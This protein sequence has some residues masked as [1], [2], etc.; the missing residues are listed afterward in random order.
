MKITEILTESLSRVAFHYASLPTALRIMQSGE[1]RLSA[2]TGSIEQQYAPKG[3]P[4]FLSATRTMTGGYHA[5]VHTSGGV[6][7]VL[8]GDWFNS[9]YPAGPVDYWGDRNP[10]TSYGRSSEAE[11]RIFSKTNAIPL[12]GV[13]A[14]HILIKDPDP[15]LDDEALGRA[16]QLMI[17]AKKQGIPAYFYTNEA[18]WRRLNTDGTADVSMLKGRVEPR[19]N[20]PRKNYLKPLQELISKPSYDSLSDKAKSLARS[21]QYTYDKKVVIAGIKN[22]FANYRKPDSNIYPQVVKII[23]FMQANKLNS[24][25]ELVDWLQNKWSTQK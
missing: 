6:V 11:D 12:G 2:S 5:T 24:I 10:T 18:A 4:Y 13:S 21:M 19:K 8:N 7:F 20:Y 15:S 9:K 23:K 1:F 22:D 3:Y 16:R 25:E 17:A 14:V